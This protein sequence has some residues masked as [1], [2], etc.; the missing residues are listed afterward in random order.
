MKHKKL[1]IILCIFVVVCISSLFLLLN[2]TKEKKQIIL[3]I[4]NETIIE[5]K[6]E[7][8]VAIIEK[9]Y[10][11]LMIVAHP[12]DETIWGGAHLI[13]GDY[14]VV[15][16][17]CGVDKK[18]QKEF[19]KVMN[20]TDSKYIMFSHTDLKKGYISDWENEIE[21]IKL[22]LTDILNE[23]N[24]N[25]II[26]HNPQG[27]YG[28]KQHKKI[29]KIVTSIVSDK[30]KLYYFGKYY[31]KEQLKKVNLVPIESQIY[32]IKS[33]ILFNIYKTQH[34]STYNHMF[35]YENWISYLDWR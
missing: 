26:T 5:Q 6:E 10:N 24:W 17:T 3:T 23:R 25:T 14:T 31:K 21:I 33:D 27:E 9:E 22:E 4:P 7:N 16:I 18:R 20:K 11:N 28:H 19:I 30:E 35:K 15:C 8:T 1:F 2:L 34:F 13:E 32:D 29:N 12:D